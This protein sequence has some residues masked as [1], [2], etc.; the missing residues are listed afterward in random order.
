MKFEGEEVEIDGVRY[1]VSGAYNPDYGDL[2]CLDVRTPSN[3][4]NHLMDSVVEDLMTELVLRLAGE[5]EF[6]F[7]EA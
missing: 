1:T 7:E 4:V 6:S 3:V 2:I 5:D